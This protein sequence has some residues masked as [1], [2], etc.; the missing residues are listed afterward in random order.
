MYAAKKKYDTIELSKN[1][2]TVMRCI[3]NEHMVVVSG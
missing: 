3:M 2:H 1:A